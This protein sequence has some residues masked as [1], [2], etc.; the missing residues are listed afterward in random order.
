MSKVGMIGWGIASN[1]SRGG[2]IVVA[3]LHY[4]RSPKR[5][6]SR[7]VLPEEPRPNQRAYLAFHLHPRPAI[8]ASSILPHELI[9]RASLV[10]LI[11]RFMTFYS[12]L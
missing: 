3:P 8:Y 6:V 4:P 10:H 11:S 5:K 1:L 12:L 7:K 9:S 2:E